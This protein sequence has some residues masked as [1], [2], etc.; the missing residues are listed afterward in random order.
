MNV[1]HGIFSLYQ[2]IEME[3]IEDNY[4]Y[5][6]NDGEKIFTLNYSC[7]ES[8]ESCLEGFHKVHSTN[9]CAKRFLTSEIENA[10]TVVTK[11]EYKG[12]EFVIHPNRKQT[13]L[14][15]LATNDDEFASKNGFVKLTNSKGESYFLGEVPIEQLT[16]I[17]EERSPY[18]SFRLPEPFLKVVILDS[19]NFLS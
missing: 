9:K 11:A 15:Q 5:P 18:M 16:Q 8:P 1:R 17:W 12:L 6:R 4:E 19:R 7:N 3:I 10:Y 13:N 14:A 2:G